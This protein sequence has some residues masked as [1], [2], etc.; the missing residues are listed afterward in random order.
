MA[1]RP[2]KTLWQHV[3]DGTFR[4]ERH[5][6]MLATEPVPP[7]LEQFAARYRAA[8]TKR[9]RDAVALDFRDAA[10]SLSRERGPVRLQLDLTPRPAGR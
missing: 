3:R 5:A 9:E 10:S 7:D 2:P 4:P 6:E 1:G 8:A